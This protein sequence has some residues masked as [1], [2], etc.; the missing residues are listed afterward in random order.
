[1][2]ISP[3]TPST[4]IAHFFENFAHLSSTNNIPSLVALY[5]D[6]FLAAGPQ[7]AQPVT[8][9]NFAPK[10]KQLFEFLGHTSTTL[11][12]VHETPLDPRYTLVRTQWRFTFARP[13]GPEDILV[14]T[15]F[16]VDTSTDPFRILLY[17]AHQ[18]IFAI[19]KDRGIQNNPS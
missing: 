13:T 12:A 4:P 16:L 7:G 9:A 15:T 11:V 14:D 3:S 8:A 1:M 17:L 10:R 19:L 5:A 2:Q 6:I 18:D